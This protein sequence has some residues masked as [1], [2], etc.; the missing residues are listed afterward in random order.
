MMK[1]DW[2]ETLMIALPI[3]A[4]PKNTLK[5]IKKCPHKNPAKSNNGLGIYIVNYNV[6]EYLQMLTK[7]LQ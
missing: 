2:I 1:N 6:F 7:E 3:N 5:G 4:A